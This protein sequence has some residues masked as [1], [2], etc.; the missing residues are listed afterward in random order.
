[1]ACTCFGSRR[2][3]N[4]VWRRENWKI[5][6]HEPFKALLECSKC[7]EEW[8]SSSRL[9]LFLLHATPRT[10]EEIAW[11]EGFWAGYASGRGD[12]DNEGNPHRNARLGKS[13]NR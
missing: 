7:E 11:D 3:D 6:S 8:W 13:Q 2:L 10:D 4:A 9:R 12:G 1:M 5:V